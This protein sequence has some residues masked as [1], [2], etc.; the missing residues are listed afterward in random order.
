MPV[1]VKHGEEV[2][3]LDVRNKSLAEAK[4]IL[5]TNGFYYTIVDTVEALD[6]PSWT[7]IDQQ[8]GPGLTVKKGKVVRLIV[9]VA[10]KYFPMPKL[11]GKV[12][13]AALLELE[14]AKLPVDSVIYDYSLD[15]PE[16]VITQQSVEAGFMVLVNTPLVLHVSKGL[17]PRQ[18]EVPELFALSLEVAKRRI[19]EAGLRVGNIREIPNRELLP[20][21]VIGQ[22]PAAGELFDQ[23]VSVNLEVT[24]T[25]I[26]GEQ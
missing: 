22:S 14:H 18:F 3:L 7:V 20:Y 5:K 4:A 17:P 21:T 19:R 26:E 24:I 25:D 8:P 9:S 13:K 2:I 11:V 6:L 15:K 10:E 12:L 16:G 23:Q 1:Y